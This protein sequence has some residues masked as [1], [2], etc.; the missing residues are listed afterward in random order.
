MADACASVT[1]HDAFSAFPLVNHPHH[2]RT[3]SRQWAARQRKTVESHMYRRGRL[4]TISH[5]QVHI[6]QNTFAPLLG[7]TKVLPQVQPPGPQTQTDS[8]KSR[9]QL[10]MV[11]DHISLQYSGDEAVALKLLDM[12][13]FEYSAEGQ[14]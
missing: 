6:I 2:P 7:R 1:V 5:V 10:T 14:D 3:S 13:T 12:E 9:G 4:G 8:K 11:I